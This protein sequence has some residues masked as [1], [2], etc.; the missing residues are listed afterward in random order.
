MLKIER[1]EKYRLQ[2]SQ[3]A[4]NDLL[5]LESEQHDFWREENYE[6]TS[7]FY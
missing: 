3:F 2:L 6:K 4:L 7:R 5:P 1:N